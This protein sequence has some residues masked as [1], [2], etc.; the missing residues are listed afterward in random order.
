MSKEVFEELI[1]F[2]RW[3]YFE[4]KFEDVPGIPAG[5]PLYDQE[6]M[7]DEVPEYLTFYDLCEKAEEETLITIW[8]DDFEVPLYCRRN[9]A[10][11]G[12]DFKVINRCKT[13]MYPLDFVYDM[14]KKDYIVYEYR[15]DEDLI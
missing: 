13:S 8:P 6:L 10:L 7:Y 4:L 5:D 3:L 15:T 14:D 2:E 9:P 1:R 12:N 11:C